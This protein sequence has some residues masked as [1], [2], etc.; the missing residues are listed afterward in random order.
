MVQKKKIHECDESSIL[1]T[2]SLF[3]GGDEWD[4]RSREFWIDN[5][6][7]ERLIKSIVRPI[8]EINEMDANLRQVEPIHIYLFTPGGDLDVTMSIVD[9]IEMSRTPVY[10]HNMGRCSS[11]GFFI[12]CAGH[13]RDSLPS[14]SFMVHE[15]RCGIQGT[16]SQ[17]RGS[18]KNVSMGDKVLLD[19]LKRKTL[20]NERDFEKM[21]AVDWFMSAEEALEY[22]VIDEIIGRSCGCDEDMIELTEEEAELLFEM[23]KEMKK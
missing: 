1:P 23:M 4:G 18:M 19:L 10:T 17:M 22:G 21:G 8:R 7:D 13:K 12:L 14:A 16:A 3:G 15:L 20:I 11:G 2:I 9:T 5:E 6:I